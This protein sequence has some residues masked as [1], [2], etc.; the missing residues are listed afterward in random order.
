MSVRIEFDYSEIEKLSTRLTN[1]G[2]SAEASMNE[3]LKK[4]GLEQVKSK[5]TPL[6]PISTRKGRER[7][8]THAATSDWAKAEYRNLELVVKPKGGAANKRGSS[9]YLVF[10]DKGIGSHNRTPLEFMD[11]GRDVAIPAIIRL[12]EID[13]LQTIE[14]EL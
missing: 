14:E 9:G 8:K 10:P 1:L 6:I 2:K 3:S 5:I 11:Q 7:N 12:L 4:Y 13:L